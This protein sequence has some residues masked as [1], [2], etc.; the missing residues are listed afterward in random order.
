LQ[1][2]EASREKPYLGLRLKLDPR[3]EHPEFREVGNR[4]LAAWNEGVTDTLST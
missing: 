1:I 2:I 4:M 3:E